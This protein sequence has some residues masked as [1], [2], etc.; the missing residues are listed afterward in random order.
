MVLFQRKEWNEAGENIVVLHTIPPGRLSPNLSPF[1]LKLELFFRA[2][3][4][5]YKVSTKIMV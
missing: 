3:N 2:A 5:T 4:I 1:V